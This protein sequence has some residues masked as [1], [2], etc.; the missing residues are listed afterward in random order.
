MVDE[1]GAEIKFQ[2]QFSEYLQDAER[3]I[4]YFCDETAIDATAFSTTA[5]ATTA[6]LSNATTH[7]NL[8]DDQ[9][10]LQDATQ[11][12]IHDIKGLI[13]ST[14][15][16]NSSI[17]PFLS[18]IPSKVPIFPDFL[19]SSTINW[20]DMLQS[21]QHSPHLHS[22]RY[23]STASR[24]NETK[25]DAPNP[26][27][28][29]IKTQQCVD[30]FG[31]ILPAVDSFPKSVSGGEWEGMNGVATVH[32]DLRPSVNS[33]DK[34]SSGGHSNRCDNNSSISEDATQHCSSKSTLWD[35]YISDF[36]TS[37]ELNNPGVIPTS[38][39]TLPSELSRSSTQFTKHHPPS[40]VDTRTLV[41]SAIEQG[42]QNNQSRDSELLASTKVSVQFHNN[43]NDITPHISSSASVVDNSI[44]I[45]HSTSTIVAS[46]V[47]SNLVTKVQVTPITSPPT[48]PSIAN[49]PAHKKK[50]RGRKSR[51]AAK[52]YA[53]AYDSAPASIRQP[54]MVKSQQEVVLVDLPVI[55][56][57]SKTIEQSVSCICQLESENLND[58]S[59]PPLPETIQSAEPHKSTFKF[60]LQAA[61]FTP[62]SPYLVFLHH[63][64][65]L[66]RVRRSWM[67]ITGCHKRM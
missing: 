5:Q 65:K 26:S 28:P 36:S 29:T 15:L 40:P 27:P 51:T 8:V 56:P 21:L 59:P 18:Y 2:S 4:G 57:A 17:Q 64:G 7:S 42:A 10:C 38:S 34:D 47:F 44:S 16:S 14:N 33:M 30:K 67:A 32:I 22:S 60:N 39:S 55:H 13:E 49:I 41:S 46:T 31:F 45:D 48:N 9:S 62:S 25:D 53:P 58:T 20:D 61:D 52:F 19:L 35:F 66:C 1:E 11:K 50:K 63:F 3:F 37:K 43:R 23:L 54:L 24:I 6:T 12:S